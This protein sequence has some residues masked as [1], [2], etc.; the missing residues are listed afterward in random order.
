MAERIPG[1]FAEVALGS[2]DTRKPRI[3]ELGE[4]VAGSRPTLH[5]VNREVSRGPHFDPLVRGIA[6]T[7]RRE[8]GRRHL[9]LVPTHPD[10]EKGIK[11]APMDIRGALGYTK[12]VELFESITDPY[13][14]LVDQF[15]GDTDEQPWI[16]FLKDWRLA[17]SAMIK[18]RGLMDFGDAIA[19]FK[20]FGARGNALLL[21]EGLTRLGIDVET[22]EPRSVVTF[23]DRGAPAIDEE[24]TGTALGLVLHSKDRA[25][26][27]LVPGQT[28]EMGDYI[29]GQKRV[30][31]G[32][33][34]GGSRETDDNVAAQA[35]VMARLTNTA[36]LNFW[37][38][39]DTQYRI[40]LELLTSQL[41]KTDTRVNFAYP[42]SWFSAWQ[43]VRFRT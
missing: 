32:F 19:H 23:V 36:E 35:M 38:P 18:A 12:G 43:E 34:S 31:A 9:V 21:Q 33:I 26:V 3:A 13:E 40:Y 22:V 8:G 39:Q 30:R 42:N 28:G 7:V 11:E 6:A 25:Q 16:K 5:V 37:V 29:R 10:I 20:S 4:T 41:E 17:Y 27:L 24:S 2:I 14:E 15:G 1:S